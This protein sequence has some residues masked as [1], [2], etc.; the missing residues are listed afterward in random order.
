[1]FKIDENLI[2]CRTKNEDPA[3]VPTPIDIPDFQRY[4]IV[5]RK[6]ETQNINT[7]KS[8]C[9]RTF[10]MSVVSTNN[11]YSSTRMHF[12]SPDSKILDHRKNLNKP[13]STIKKNSD[14]GVKSH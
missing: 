8:C 3:I 1:M 6:Q 13:K 5:H 10:E 7:F 12:N 2:S 4:K 11:L 9:S 14:S